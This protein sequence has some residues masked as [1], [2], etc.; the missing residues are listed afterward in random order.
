M[1]AMHMK[2]TNS[3][4]IPRKALP[5]VSLATIPL[6]RGGLG[7]SQDDNIASDGEE[8]KSVVRVVSV[9]LSER[10]RSREDGIPREEDT[11]PAGEYVK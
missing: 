1:A 11:R 8:C 10:S 4:T 5:S 3:E 6:R 7:Y 2:K 9:N